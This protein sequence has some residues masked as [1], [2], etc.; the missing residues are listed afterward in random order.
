VFPLTV[1]GVEIVASLVLFSQRRAGRPGGWQPWLAIA[2]GSAASLVAN[3]A[4]TVRYSNDLA[5]EYLTARQ[6]FGS[7]I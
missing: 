7:A 2:V 5:V 4:G 6:Q 1:D 3:A